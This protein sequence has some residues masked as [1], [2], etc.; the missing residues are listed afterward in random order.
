MVD[1]LFVRSRKLHDVK[2][3]CIALYLRVHY[4]HLQK[5][6]DRALVELKRVA[7]FILKTSYTQY[8]FGAWSSIIIGY[9]NLGR[10]NEAIRELGLMQDKALAMHDDYGVMR[11]YSLFGDMY[12]NQNSYF[13]AYLQYKR[14][15]QYGEEHHLQDLSRPYVTIGV[16]SMKL[17]RWDEAEYYLTK[18]L[19]LNT[20]ETALM[21]PYCLLLSLYCRQDSINP[22][23]IDETFNRLKYLVSNNSLQGT[24]IDDYN[25]SMYYYYQF[26]KN[27]SLAAEP[28]R[29][30]KIKVDSLSYFLYF[31]KH[32]EALGRYK[33]AAEN[34]ADY[35]AWY[36]DWNASNERFLH[37]SFVPQ[38]D[39][40]KVAI[41]KSNLLRLQAQMKMKN[42]ESEARLLTLSTEKYQ[43][44]LAAK[45][46]E[47]IILK[48][49][50]EAK[51]MRAVRQN[52]QIAYDRLQLALHQKERK[53]IQH[54]E[55]WEIMLGTA[56]TFAILLLLSFFIFFKLKERIRLKA[57][58]EKAERSERTKSLFFQ[59]MNHE[60]RSPLNAIVG[61]NELL[62]SDVA[63]TLST[64]EKSDII[65]MITTNSHLLMTLVNDVLDLSNFESGTYKL[66]PVDVDINSLCHTTLESIRGRQAE[67]VELAFEPHPEGPYILHTDAQRLQQVLVNYLTNACKYTEKGRITL[68]YEVLKDWV[69]FSVTD[70]GCGVKPED[71]EKVFLRFQMLD[72]SKRGTGLGLHIC[73]LVSKLLH[74]KTYVDTSY[75]DGARFI[76]DHPLKGAIAILIGFL[77]AFSPLQ[78][79]T[80]G[81]EVNDNT[82]YSYNNVVSPKKD[83]AVWAHEL[84]AKINN[85]EFANVM[86]QLKEFQKAAALEKDPYATSLF[87]EVSAYFYLRLDHYSIALKYYHQAL[88]Y[89]N[90]NAYNIYLW[91]ACCYYRMNNYKD[92]KYNFQRALPGLKI[93]NHFLISYSYLLLICS[94]ENDVAGANKYFN[95][96]ESLKPKYTKI[97]DNMDVYQNAVRS[98]YTNIKKNQKM[99][100]E[101]TKNDKAPTISYNVGNWF[102]SIG[103]YK[104]AMKEYKDYIPTINKLMRN[105]YTLL[106]ESFSS[107]FDYDKELNEKKRVELN[108]IQLKLH[109]IENNKRLLELDKQKMQWNL[110]K[111]EVNVKQ[112]KSE[113]LL[114]NGRLLQQSQYMR[115]QAL[116][117]AS[118]RESERLIRQ[119]NKLESLTFSVFALAIIGVALAYYYYLRR[120]DRKL[121][122]EAEKALAAEHEK[123]TFFESINNKIRKPLDNII[124]L[125]TRLNSDEPLSPEERNA[126]TANLSDSGSFLTNMVNR[127]LDISKMESGTFKLSCVNADFHELCQSVIT[128]MKDEVPMGVEL[129]FRPAFVDASNEGASC[130]VYGDVDQLAFMVKA[131][132]QNAF[133]HTKSGSV[134]LGYELL[135]GMLRCFVA[136][137]GCGVDEAIADDIFYCERLKGT[138]NRVGLSLHMVR[139]LAGLMKGK[140]YLDRTYTKGARFVFE[141]PLAP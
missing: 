93:P 7:P 39:Y 9:L 132:L 62:S 105:D 118:A 97:L 10:N 83:F 100:Q 35:S 123:N 138:T 69:R 95:I 38:F 31:G 30:Q 65:G 137:T 102:F 109:Q 73:R 104:K 130:M 26:Y 70:T 18:C 112:K 47:H 122:K 11:N 108:N 131:Y 21:T 74:G 37:S 61:F 16:A 84:M 106:F 58:K 87:L 89:S 44:Y 28:Y 17:R 42:T 8:Y 88:N 23:K 129:E 40:Q 60:I 45:L 71:A 64:K 115:N 5:E 111:E 85:S 128:R 80:S 113:I 119:Q 14:A 48:N 15:I 101:A 96:L 127:V 72:K 1:T 36:F 59:N 53:L 99:G 67:G 75:R 133:Q 114:Q 126:L 139:L 34:Y 29:Q 22:Q 20:D 33:E 55:H 92:A 2:A 135:P 77:F 13:F 41:E 140:A 63:D 4:Y 82:L 94:A 57:E 76:F 68:S 134:A 49:Q 12:F 43:A 32:Y 124:T 3:Q 6:D 116:L 52:K 81:S 46:R 125:N 103:E 54:N 56:F 25:A 79:H 98:Y 90:K 110:N 50:L 24:W 91:M 78:A 120:N 117:K 136:D 66:V 51:K 19:R 107:K 121:K 141:I 27:D 86:P